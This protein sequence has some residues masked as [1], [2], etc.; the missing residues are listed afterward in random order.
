[1]D[2]FFMNLDATQPVQT[3]SRLETSSHADRDD[4]VARPDEEHLGTSREAAFLQSGV[5]LERR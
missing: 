1:M 3:T 2:A 4:D 5:C